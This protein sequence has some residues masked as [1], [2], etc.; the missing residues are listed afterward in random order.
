MRRTDKALTAIKS[1]EEIITSSTV[2]R[3]ALSLDDTPYVVPM[4]FGYAAETIYFHSAREGKKIDIIKKNNKVCFEF[5]ID[6]EI[7]KSEKACKWSMK[8]RSV[9]GFGKASFIDN[10][11]EKQHA[12][13]IIMQNYTDKTFQ[14]PEKNLENTLVI[15]IDI[16]HMVGKQSG[17]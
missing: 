8:F 14:F 11:E 6:H 7:V 10:M 5:D 2:C 17:Y 3:L 16:D 1:I 13:N 12:L 9:I 4:S 15:K